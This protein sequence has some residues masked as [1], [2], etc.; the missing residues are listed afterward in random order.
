MKTT[1]TVAPDGS[2]IEITDSHQN[3]SEIAQ[4]AKGDWY[5]KSV[6]VYATDSVAEEVLLKQFSK[7]ASDQCTALNRARAEA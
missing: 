5:V 6:K 3:S 2:S 1:T 4:S 7:T